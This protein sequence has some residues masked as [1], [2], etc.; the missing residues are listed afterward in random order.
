MPK[1][2]NIPRLDY[3][4]Y[5]KLSNFKRCYVCMCTTQKDSNKF[6]VEAF[7]VIK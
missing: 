5:K 2:Q 6:C 1:T 7:P 3:L 4:P